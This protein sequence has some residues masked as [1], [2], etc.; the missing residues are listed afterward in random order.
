MERIKKNSNKLK[1]FKSEDA[2]KLVWLND[3]EIIL[4]ERYLIYFDGDNNP[5]NFN[6][7]E[8]IDH[9]KDC[10]LNIDDSNFQVIEEENFNFIIGIND[11]IENLRPGA[12]YQLE[13]KTF[14]YW[15]HNSQPPS[16]EE[17]SLHMKKMQEELDAN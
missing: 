12:K 15:E 4:S 16:W 2:Y 7:T 9:K 5:I 13:N 17:I 8:I 3:D 6:L 14:T 11:A 1:I 10:C